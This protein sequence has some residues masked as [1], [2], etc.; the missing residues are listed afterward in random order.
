MGPGL[1]P[2]LVGAG[3]ILLGGLLVLAVARGERFEPQDA[4]D[5]DPTRPPSRRALWTAVAAGLAPIP[6]IRLLGFPIG[7][8]LAFALTARAFGSRRWPI[9]L[10]LGLLLG[11]ACWALFSRVLGLALP[12]FPFLGP[13]W[14]R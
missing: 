4:E 6:V 5:A 9:D 8:A 10:L 11:T 13:A 14:G 12:G 1:V 2:A 3:L 7:A